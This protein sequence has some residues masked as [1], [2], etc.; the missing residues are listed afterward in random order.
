[1]PTARFSIMPVTLS[2]IDVLRTVAS[3]IDARHI[4]RTVRCTAH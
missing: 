2:M 4:I 1:M 3:Q